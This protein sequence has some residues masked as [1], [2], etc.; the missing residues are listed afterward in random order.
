MSN[1]LS[2]MQKAMV[3]YVQ[4]IRPDNDRHA[5]AELDAAKQAIEDSGTWQDYEEWRISTFFDTRIER[6]EVNGIDW[7][8]V[9]VECDT[10]V[11]SCRCPSLEKAYLHSKFYRRLIVDQFY[12]VGPPWA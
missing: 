11:F 1:N 5:L 6:T 4:S 7:F 10:Q 8:N 3:D 9:R 12:S 2:P